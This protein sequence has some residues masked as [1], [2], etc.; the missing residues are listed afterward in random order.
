MK[1]EIETQHTGL[2]R[3]CDDAGKQFGIHEYTTFN[4]SYSDEKENRKE[5][6]KQYKSTKGEPVD[7]IDHRQFQLPNTTEWLSKC[8][9]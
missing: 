4:I 7:H 2:F 5:V 6:S 3:I 8:P 1:T 9:G